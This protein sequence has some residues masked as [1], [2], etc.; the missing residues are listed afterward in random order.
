[1]HTTLSTKPGRH[2]H[3]PQPGPEQAPERPQPRPRRV[4]PIDRLALHMG[5]ALIK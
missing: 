1:M 2:D 3:P 4:G 5:V